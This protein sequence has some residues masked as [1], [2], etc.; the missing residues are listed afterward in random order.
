MTRKKI[1]SFVGILSI[2]FVLFGCTTNNAS[3]QTQPST[4]TVASVLNNYDLVAPDKKVYEV[5]SESSETVKI[6]F[7]HKD[8]QKKNLKD[9]VY[10]RIMKDAPISNIKVLEGEASPD[11]EDRIRPY[12]IKSNENYDATTQD[13]RYSKVRILRKNYL[14]Q[15]IVTNDK[16]DPA[17]VVFLEK[18]DS[19]T[20]GVIYY[21]IFLK[22]G[23]QGRLTSSSKNTN[24]KDILE[25]CGSSSANVDINDV[26]G[27]ISLGVDSATAKQ[28]E[29]ESKAK[30]EKYRAENPPEGVG[31][32]SRKMETIVKIK[33]I[34][35]NDNN[36]TRDL[37][38][39]VFAI[40]DTKT[41]S[42]EPF[43][44]RSDGIV[45]NHS[46]NISKEIILSK[47]LL[48]IGKNEFFDSAQSIKMVFEQM[49]I[50]GLNQASSPLIEI[51]VA[52]KKYYYG[53]SQYRTEYKYV[54]NG[55]TKENIGVNYFEPTTTILN[56][57]PWC[58]FTPES[59]PAIYLYKPIPGLVN[60]KLNPQGGWLSVSIPKYNQSQGWN[61]FATPWGDIFSGFKR[62]SHLFYEAMLQTPAMPDKF[63]TL[64][65]DSLYDQLFDLG[66]RLSLNQ[67][68]A[69][70]LADY[71][72][73]KLPK[74]DYYKVGLMEPTEIDRVEPVTINPKPNSFYRVR[75]IFQPLDEFVA[76]NTSFNANFTRSGFAV[77]EWGGFV[78]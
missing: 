24:L 43:Y 28:N 62:Y 10:F 56:G 17:E 13:V 3:T 55:N 6:D 34:A 4:Q 60:V 27:Q 35:G 67:K 15:Q 51:T 57:D 59:K 70:E 30:Q 45:I 21:D 38:D 25:D 40:G 5:V 41:P 71:W 14:K 20:N 44:R 75:L 58:G 16:N 29:Q 50:S 32:I 74:S 22:N 47:E 68:E 39:D 73:K 11:R 33:S 54:G 48:N 76:P 78:I 69:N 26:S 61:V 53:P 31:P 19:Y 7:V 49:N 36:E 64:S 66:T 72:I 1:F 46:P 52:G 37:I 42:F 2:S 65:S 18:K 8:D 9:Q 77:V 23:S 63:E 12:A